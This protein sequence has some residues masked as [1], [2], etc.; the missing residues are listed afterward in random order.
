V[1]LANDGLVY[2]CD[3]INNRIQVFRKDGTFVKEW[4]LREEHARQRRG[5]GHR[6]LA[7]SEADL[8]C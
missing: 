4:F 2:V 7:R 8:I 1:K 5:L 6:D 3:R